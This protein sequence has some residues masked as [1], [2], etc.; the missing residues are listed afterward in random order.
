MKEYKDNIFT[1]EE[2]KTMK[3]AHSKTKRGKKKRK[4]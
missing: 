1:P 3:V 2:F 4:K